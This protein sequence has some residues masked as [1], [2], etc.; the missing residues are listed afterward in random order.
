MNVRV[1]SAVRV[2]GGSFFLAL[3]AS[4]IRLGFVHE[5]SGLPLHKIAAVLEACLG[6]WMVLGARRLPGVCGVLLG[7][8]ML[9]RF[10]WYVPAGR[11]RAACG[12]LGGAVE[13]RPWQELVLIAV[14]VVL[15]ATVVALG[16]GGSERRSWR[17]GRLYFLVAASGLGYA[18]SYALQAIF[19]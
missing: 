14:V 13:L 17:W 5:A 7:A 8:G 19:E 9:A 6:T 15:S 18:G 12:C 2:L 10:L 16:S 4:K 11:T 3:V 1:G